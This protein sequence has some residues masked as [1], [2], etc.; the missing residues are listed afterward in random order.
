MPN[1]WKE[2][3][4][5]ELYK[6][7]FDRINTGTVW[8]FKEHH[9]GGH[10]KCLENINELIVKPN[11]EYFHEFLKKYCDIKPEYKDSKEPFSI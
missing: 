11:R 8:P 4:S 10:K 7:D 5:S 1:L 6:D 2:I 9:L 3:E